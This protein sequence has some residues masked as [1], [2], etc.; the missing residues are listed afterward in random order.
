MALDAAD[1]FWPVALRGAK[2]SEAD[3]SGA[4][5]C[6]F[7]MLQCLNCGRNRG[8]VC[9]VKYDYIHVSASRANRIH[10]VTSKSGFRKRLQTVDE[11]SLSLF[12]GPGCA[13]PLRG[14]YHSLTLKADPRADNVYVYLVH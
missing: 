13:P 8:S 5:T 4:L 1:A 2:L 11:H 14:G 3:H 12:F 6:L 7:I 9:T 10:Y